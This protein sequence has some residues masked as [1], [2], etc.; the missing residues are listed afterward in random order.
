M[1]EEKKP[2]IYYVSFL[3]PFSKK[4]EDMCRIICWIKALPLFFKTGIWCPHIYKE[5]TRSEEI[6]IA[7]NKSFRVADN[8]LHTSNETVHPHATLITSKCICCGK[9]DFSWTDGRVLQ[10]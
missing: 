2:M 7:T 3:I 4:G 1:K 5:E 6:I 10:L 8:Y 9:T